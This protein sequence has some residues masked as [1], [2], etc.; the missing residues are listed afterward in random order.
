MIEGKWESFVAP[1]D[2]EFFSDGSCVVNT[3]VERNLRGKYSV[4]GKVIEVFTIDEDGDD[5]VNTFD[6]EHSSLI[7][8]RPPRG[9]DLPPLP[10]S[11]V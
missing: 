6:V 11:R 8:M 5:S 4:S 7:T 2:V 9:R 1:F 10:F 3:P